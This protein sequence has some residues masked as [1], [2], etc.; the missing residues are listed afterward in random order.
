MPNPPIREI[1]RT[2]TVTYS[3]ADNLLRVNMRTRLVVRNRRGLN[4]HE[5]KTLSDRAD[6]L[7]LSPREWGE[8][9][10]H[11]WE[12]MAQHVIDHPSSHPPEPPHGIDR[13]R[14]H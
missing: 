5:T 3:E 10:R 12:A 11:G 14:S 8:L 13:R 2:F 1:V 4:Y 9:M 6:V 7:T